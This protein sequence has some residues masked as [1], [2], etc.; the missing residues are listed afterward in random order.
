MGESF[1]SS[2]ELE[3][4]KAIKEKVCFVALNY[5][6]EAAA[7]EGS[8]QLDEVYELPDKRKITIPGKLRMQA[9]ELIFKPEL[10]GESCNS[11]HALAWKSVSSSD[12][13]VRKDLCKNVILSG[14]TTMYAGIAERLKQEL[15]ALAPAGSE[16]ESLPL[17]TASTPSG[18]VPPPS[19]L[20]ALS[21][22]AGSARASTTSMVRPSSTASASE[23]KYLLVKR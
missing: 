4:V 12:I 3:I 10:N 16:S 18:R 9:P 1:T 2:A 13:D 8:S 23:L 15:E 20:L 7:A 14:G 19:P 17:P 22:P 6:E 11:L 5:D 21:V